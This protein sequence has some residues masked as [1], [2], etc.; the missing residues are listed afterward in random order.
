MDYHNGNN[1]H[2]Q[3]T[4]CCLDSTK[5]CLPKMLP[6]IFMQCMATKKLVRGLPKGGTGIMKIDKLGTFF[7]LNK[8]TF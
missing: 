7:F 2:I 5:M 1:K 6:K 4:V 8:C 3:Y